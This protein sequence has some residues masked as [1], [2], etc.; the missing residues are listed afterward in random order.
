[1]KNTIILVITTCF[2]FVGFGFAQDTTP[3]SERNGIQKPGQFRVPPILK[4]NLAI[5]DLID[6]FR[7]SRETFQG[8]FKALRQEIAEANGEDIAALKDRLRTLLKSNFQAQRDFR[9]EVRKIARVAREA[10][11]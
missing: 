4:D 1:M 7:S 10:G 9:R 2:L 3:V 8:D 6:D 11:E 5:Q